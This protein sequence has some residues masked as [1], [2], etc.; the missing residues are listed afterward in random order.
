MKNN[1]L[2]QKLKNREN[3]T[4][5]WITIGHQAI[6]D[7]MA[8]AGFEWLTIDIEHTPIDYNEIQVLIGFIQSRGMAALV[9]VSKNEE[10]VIKRVLD[11]GADGVIVPMVC[12]AEDAK[13]AVEYA[14]YPPIGKRG[15][16]LN[17]AQRYGFG[18]E[19]YKEWVKENLVVIA[20]IEHIKGV[21]NIQEI[22]ATEG[23]DGIIIGPYDLSGSLGIPGQYNE[24]VVVEAL[25]RVEKACLENKFSMG[26]HVIE[27]DADLVKQK[28]EAGYNFIAFSTDFLFMGKKAAYEMG[29]YKTA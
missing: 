9:R 16:G 13:Q 28:N 25:Q 21:E 3:T 12:S 17:R 11:A 18:F 2:K 4:G 26:Y 20:Q 23:I 29:R 6:I 7:I 19:Q 1:T 5:S 10:V 8:E 27:P 22:I 24:P 14:K 15:V